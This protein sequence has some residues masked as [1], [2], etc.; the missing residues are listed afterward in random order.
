MASSEKTSTQ[1]VASSDTD[2]QC[3]DVFP[4]H[5][6]KKENPTSRHPA[7]SSSQSDQ[8]ES[9]SSLTCENS[10]QT[11]S[12]A[13][14]TLGLV[15]SVVEEKSVDLALTKAE[16]K[17]GNGRVKTPRPVEPKEISQHSDATN[18]EVKHA[19]LQK[20]READDNPSPKRPKKENFVPDPVDKPNLEHRTVVQTLSEVD[21]VNDGYRWRKYGQKLVK[22]NPNPSAWK[23]RVIFCKID[24]AHDSYLM[25]NIALVAIFTCY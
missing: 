25:S 22:G 8:Q 1:D 9:V 3:Y 2:T 12:Q 14:S 6:T 13:K 11:A 10:L 23:C 19:R 5:S 20:T 18:D 15:V 17:S 24:I 4:L 16:N 21:I 7:V